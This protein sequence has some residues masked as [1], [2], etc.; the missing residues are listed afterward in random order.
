AEDRA[1]VD[2]R[3]GVVMGQHERR[4]GVRHV[5]DA[6]EIDIVGPLPVLLA[7]LE[8]APTDLEAGIVDERVHA[9]ETIL[10]HLRR[11]LDL[12]LVGDVAHTEDR[13]LPQISDLLLRLSA[14]LLVDID[15]H[16]VVPVLRELYRRGQTETRGTSTDDHH[17]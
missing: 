1:G 16:T 10:R 15:E 2:D 12:R 9:P 11:L 14:L 5:V 7:A 17:P 3:A 4:E 6:L 13:V 8:D